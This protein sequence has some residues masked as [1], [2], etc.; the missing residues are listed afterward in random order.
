MTRLIRILMSRVRSRITPEIEQKQCNFVHD[1]G[2][3]NIIMIRILQER[4]VKIQKDLYLFHRL[5]N[6]H[7][8]R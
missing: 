2:T 6:K 4:A 5:Q 8:I 1:T 3:K 7:L